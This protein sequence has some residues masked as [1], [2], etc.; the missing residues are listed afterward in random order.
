MPPPCVYLM[1]GS[2]GFHKYMYILCCYSNWS[3]KAVVEMG[4][5]MLQKQQDKREAMLECDGENW[6]SYVQPCRDR[7]KWVFPLIP[8]SLALA[9]AKRIAGGDRVIIVPLQSTTTHT[10]CKY[11]YDL[12]VISIPVKW[13]CLCRPENSPLFTACSFL[14]SWGFSRK[15]SL[16]RHFEARV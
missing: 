4:L 13:I 8:I 14:L 5:V 7:E 10:R 1:G 15:R 2:T 6:E 3:M 11:G 12:F 9:G 16:G